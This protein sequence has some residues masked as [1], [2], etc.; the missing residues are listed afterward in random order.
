MLRFYLN[1][2]SHKFPQ[3]EAR[4]LAPIGQNKRKAQS[5]QLVLEYV[6]LMLLAVSIA[7]LI[8]NEIIG[9]AQPGN[10]Q[11]ARVLSK[12]VCEITRVIAEDLPGE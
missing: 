11:E 5:G 2:S 9:E 7:S 6:L 8:K 12:M 3:K 4:P 10:C 1:T